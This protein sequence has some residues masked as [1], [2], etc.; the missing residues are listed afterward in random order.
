MSKVVSS[1]FSGFSLSGDSQTPLYSQLQT[2]I[3]K[4]MAL[5]DFRVDEAIPA[6][7]EMAADLGVSRVTVRKAVSG[8]VEEGLLVQR[9]GVGTFVKGRMEQ[10]SARLTGFTEEMT[11]RGMQPGVKWLDRS[12]GTATPEEAMALN[13]SPN[14]EVS[15]LARIRYGSDEAVAM[16]YT[17][18]PREFLPFPNIVDLSLYAVLERANYSPYRAL[19]RLRAELFD[20]DM[21]ELLNLKYNS[22]ALYVERRSF[23]KDGRAV[24]YTRSYYRGDSYDYVAELHLDLQLNNYLNGTEQ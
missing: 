16:E 20:A 22:V 19:Q 2:L 5:G 21:A 12:I 15:R 11:K 6:E 9:H 1:I 14:T 24:E 10:P 4:A 7:R 8:L 3:K 17:T 23:L 13:L 18:V